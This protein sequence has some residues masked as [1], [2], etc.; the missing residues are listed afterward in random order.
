M[1][2]LSCRIT[3][4]TRALCHFKHDRRHLASV[5]DWPQRNKLL[6][7]C[8]SLYTDSFIYCDGFFFPQRSFEIKCRYNYTY[9]IIFKS[10]TYIF[11]SSD[12]M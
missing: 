10:F 2:L 11:F 9:T 7:Q 8:L 1:A 4:Q 5:I 12:A 3:P 6:L